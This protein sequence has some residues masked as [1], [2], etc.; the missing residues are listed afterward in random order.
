[1]F[2]QVIHTDTFNTYTYIL[3]HT[4]T[5]T[6]IHLTISVG[7]G[8]WGAAAAA[9]GSFLQRNLPRSARMGLRMGSIS[10]F[11]TWRAHGRSRGA[12]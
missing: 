4:H 8:F 5:Y 7:R 12:A 1:M 11:C 3:I 6:Y 9:R 2:I 10:N